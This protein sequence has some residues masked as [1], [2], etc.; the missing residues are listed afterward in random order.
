LWEVVSRL[1]PWLFTFLLFFGLY[2]WVPNVEVERRA[3]LWGAV[4][5][6][7]AWEVVKN[8]FVL[9]LGSGLVKYELVYGSL[10]AVVALMLWI[11]LGGWITLFGAHLSAA[12]AGERLED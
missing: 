2:L 5:A 1:I 12:I 7:I 9:Y 3:A 11:Y 10:G 6:A 8:G 4:A